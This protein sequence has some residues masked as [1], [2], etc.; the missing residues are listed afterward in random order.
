MSYY[1]TKQNAY[2]L[3]LDSRTTIT[4][5]DSTIWAG[6]LSDS[7]ADF[8]LFMRPVYDYFDRSTKRVPVADVYKMD[9]LDSAWLHSRPVI[10]GV[11]VKMLSDPAMWKKWAK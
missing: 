9:A 11:Y 6:V 7:P 3:P 8:E 4:K 1:L 2:G 10:G 5:T